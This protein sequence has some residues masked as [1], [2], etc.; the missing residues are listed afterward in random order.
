MRLLSSLP[1]KIVPSAAIAGPIGPFSWPAP[2]PKDPKLESGPKATALAGSPARA[3]AAMARTQRERRI[4]LRCLTDRSREAFNETNASST[5][6]AERS[7]RRV[8]VT[9]GSL[10]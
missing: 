5:V 6:P 9:G 4:I 10:P 7:V 2:S 8:R 1:T 3:E